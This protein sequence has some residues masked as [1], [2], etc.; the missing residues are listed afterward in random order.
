MDRIENEKQHRD[1]W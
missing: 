1:C